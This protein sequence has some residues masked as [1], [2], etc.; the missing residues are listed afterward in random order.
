MCEVWRAV[1]EARERL[2]VLER[3]GLGVLGDEVG[4]RGA[5]EL[6][7]VFDHEG[8]G[9]LVE[10]TQALP[11]AGVGDDA[12][13]ELALARAQELVD[14]GA[15]E[16]RVARVGLDRRIGATHQLDGRAAHVV[17]EAA[18]PHVRRLLLDGLEL[19]HIRPSLHRL[20]KLDEIGRHPIT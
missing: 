20:G 2:A 17:A 19:E 15:L 9:V 13:A 6:G 4:L 16:G 7:G 1:H 11:D 12:Q 18:Q 5:K 10:R 3:D 14:G 8:V